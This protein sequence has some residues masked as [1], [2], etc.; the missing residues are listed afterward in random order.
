M[1]RAA[2][3]AIHDLGY[4]P[5]R[6]PRRSVAQRFRVIARNVVAVAWRSRWGVKMPLLATLGGIL[7]AC[8]VMYI[9]RNLLE[10]AL[11]ARGMPI[12]KAQAVMFYSTLFFGFP[13]FILALVVG[14][15]TIA[16]DLKTSAFQFYFAR[17]IR[18][19]D[20]VLGKLV[21]IALL[22][23]IPTLA[24]PIILAL[25]RLLLADSWNAFAK[26]LALLPR[27]GAAG[28]AA[29]LGYSLPAAA[30][31]ALVKK[32]QLAQALFAIY[33]LVIGGLADGLSIVLKLPLLK[34]VT[35]DDNLANI[36]QALYGIDARTQM[37]PA[38]AS[39]LAI[40]TLGGMSVAIVYARIRRVETAGLGGG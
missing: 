36:A 33:F 30:F 14:G 31:G 11:Q 7:V 4:E 16:D 1:K 40:A 32:R 29:V 35:I 20:Y 5:Y 34:L 27:V 22:V 10:P 39:A 38:W 13:G 8:A 17:P 37:P 28:L 18:P 6:G 9:S 24:A 12:A 25:F 2:K 3:G 15:T 23:G 21:G 26:D 19:K